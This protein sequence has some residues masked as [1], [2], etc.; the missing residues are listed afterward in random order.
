M[1]EKFS[2]EA[3]LSMNVQGGLPKSSESF[4]LVISVPKHWHNK[5]CFILC[6]T[7]P[8]R[9]SGF[10]SQLAISETLLEQP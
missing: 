10:P 7:I 2:L 6:S 1:L 5:F 3:Y 4:M 8:L 9:G